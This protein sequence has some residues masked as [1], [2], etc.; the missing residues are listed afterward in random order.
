[1]TH[2]THFACNA[3]ITL[4]HSESAR[5]QARPGLQEEAEEEE[6]QLQLERQERAA[7]AAAAALLLWLE[8]AAVGEQAGQE[9]REALAALLPPP[10]G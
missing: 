8:L 10:F 5:K 1:M 7:A 3:G 4:V 2:S 9:A 6:P